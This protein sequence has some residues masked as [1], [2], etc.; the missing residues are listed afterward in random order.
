VA[1]L[2]IVHGAWGGGWRWARVASLLRAAGHDVFTPTL[3]GLGE[4]AHLARPEI[5]LTTHVQDVVNVLAYEDLRD[6]ALVGH[7]YGGMVVTGVAD[8]VPERL[9]QLV[10]LDAYVPRDGES[11]LDVIDP[12]RRPLIEEQVRTLG[13][14]WRIPA[15]GPIMDWRAEVAQ[16]FRTYAE[17][18]RLTNPAAAAI[19]RTYVRCT[20]DSFTARRDGPAVA[21]FAPHA[22]RARAAGWRYREL[23][24]DH[25]C[26]RTSPEAVAELLLELV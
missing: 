16:P 22:E 17:P 11:M 3:T 15:P 21:S 12:A 23:E 8:R 6:V 14:G 20:I 13:E 18:I 1:T 2:V 24:A 25:S 7:S 9:G 5:D 4:R 10:Y 19:P 26:A